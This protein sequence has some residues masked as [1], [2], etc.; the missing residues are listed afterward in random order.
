ML[1]WSAR[2]AFRA[3]VDRDS[4]I[5]C[6][7][8]EVGGKA[9]EKAQEGIGGEGAIGGGRAEES[10]WRWMSEKL[11]DALITG[12]LIGQNDEGGRNRHFR[13]GDL[14]CT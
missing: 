3:K 4:I 9:E 14:T 11:H 6:A 1:L 8:I 2:G 13:S 10:R 5:A 7:E 12:P